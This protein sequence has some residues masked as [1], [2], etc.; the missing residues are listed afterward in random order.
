MKGVI[1][2]FKRW[3]DIQMFNN[4]TM[5]LV[6]NLP[7]GLLILKKFSTSLSDNTN[8]QSKCQTQKVQDKY[9]NKF[10]SF[11]TFM[12]FYIGKLGKVSCNINEKVK[13]KIIACSNHWV[14]F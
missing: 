9:A 3:I 2:T 1:S 8:R 14:C 13:D 7:T 6:K 4:I 10:T 11:L 12:N 5:N